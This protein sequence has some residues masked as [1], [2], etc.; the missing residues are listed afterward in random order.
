M[1]FKLRLGLFWSLFPGL[2]FA[3]AL[4]PEID[5]AVSG[6][7]YNG[8][9]FPWSSGGLA[10]FFHNLVKPTA[11]VLAGLLL[12]MTLL[13]LFRRGSW[14]RWVF[15]WLALVLGPGLVTNVIF[16]DHWG[17]ARP[18]QV[19]A[20]GGLAQF[21]PALEP[22]NQCA[23]NCSFVSGDAS[24]GFF[25]HSF[26]YIAPRRRRQL[27]WAG[28]GMG[29]LCGLMRIGMGA[30]FL[31]D[32]LFGGVFTLLVSAGLY[33]ALFGRRAL[34][35]MWRDFLGLESASGGRIK[36]QNL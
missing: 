9:N 18:M 2:A 32:V 33:G 24:F 7:F 31:S 17:R 34:A 25:F 12:L 30:H 28:M 4:S 16:K 8:T 35:I 23:K 21:T 22:A 10:E 29:V 1:T 36:P 14:R 6:F 27:F 13:Q 3:V 5:L 19:E 26:A 15:V 11:L 20:F